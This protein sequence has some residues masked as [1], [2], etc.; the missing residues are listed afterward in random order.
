MKLIPIVMLSAVLVGWY[1]ARQEN[2]QT[3]SKS[4]QPTISPVLAPKTSKAVFYQF[5]DEQMKDLFGAETLCFRSPT[6]EMNDRYLLLTRMVEKRYRRPLEI[7]RTTAY[8]KRSELIMAGCWISNDVP[9]IDLIVPALIDSYN[10]LVKTNG[11]LVGEQLFK[12]CAAISFIHELDH[13]AHGYVSINHQNKSLDFLIEIER[14]AWA[15]T[16]EFTIRPLVEKHGIALDESDQIYYED[17]VK[18]G[19]DASSPIW[20]DSIRSAYSDARR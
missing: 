20:I 2:R 6:P 16:C 5:W 8:N 19:R 4:T 1:L 13:L 9:H 15:Q 7:N 10:R 11:Q 17:W 14:L 12:T 3:T 18:A